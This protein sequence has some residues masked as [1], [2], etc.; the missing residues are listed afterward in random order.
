LEVIGWVQA[1]K[2]VDI[3]LTKRKDHHRTGIRA[4]EEMMRDFWTVIRDAADGLL[5]DG[6]GAGLKVS[7]FQVRPKPANESAIV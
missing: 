1:N 5:S 2:D 4:G 7:D 3:S 6:N